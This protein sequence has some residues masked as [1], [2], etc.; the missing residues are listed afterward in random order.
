M[1]RKREVVLGLCT[2]NYGKVNTWDKT[3]KVGSV[4]GFPWCQLSLG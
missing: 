1:T 4:C 3:N 2:E